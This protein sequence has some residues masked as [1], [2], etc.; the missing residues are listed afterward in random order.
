MFCIVLY[1]FTIQLQ[2]QNNPIQLR[3]S[4][5]KSYPIETIILQ[6][7]SFGMDTLALK[8]YLQPLQKIKLHSVV[9]EAFL[10]NGYG[11]FYKARNNKSDFHYQQSIEKASALNNSALEI[12]TQF[13]YTYY[14]YHNR[15]Y[16]NMTPPLLKLTSWIEKTDPEE[17]ILPGESF[18]K[19]GWMMQTLTDYD[20]ALHYLN[21]AKKYTPKE[22]TEYAAVLDAIGLNYLIIENLTKAESYFNQVALLATQI[23]DRVRYAKALGNLAV[24]KQKRG[25]LKEAISL[26]NKDLKIS[27]SEKSDQNTLYASILLTDMYVADENWSKAEE[28]LQKAQHIVFLNPYFKREELKI[29][30]LK[31][32]IL[33]HQNKTD[34]EL[35]LRRRLFTLED[36]LKNKDSDMVIN[37]SNWLIQKTKYN[38]KINQAEDQFKQEVAM[39]NIYAAIILL[40]FLLGLVL[41]KYFK[42]QLKTKQLLHQQKIILFELENIKTEK[43]LLQAHESLNS[44]IKYLRDK[45]SQ[46]KKLK[47]EI[48][49]IKDSSSNKNKTGKLKRLL[50]SHLMTENRWNTFKREFQKEHPKFY[51]MLENDFPEI[52]DSNKRILLLEKLSFSKKEIAELLGVTP[53]AIKKSKQRLKKKIGDKFDILF[54]NVKY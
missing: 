22:T 17:L 1:L 2:S 41:F 15:D 6:E 28:I 51:R 16:V 13:N 31:L 23:N 4:E 9:Y 49:Q 45:N 11:D 48:Q 42:K 8:N 37:N 20:T 14:L 44:Q 33:K 38:Q 53:D 35:M 43:K 27:E 46:I 7:K 32:A 47:I 40:V 18:K 25:N 39:K 30:K 21:I 3:S 29:I 50:E 24:V 36:S 12:W 26:I 10:A 54:D 52:T 19:I 5:Y 34:G